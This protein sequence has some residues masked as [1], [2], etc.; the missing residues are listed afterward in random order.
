MR[1]TIS[2]VLE[3]TLHLVL[4]WSEYA[5]CIL[6]K[7][8][9]GL[10]ELELFI[11]RMSNVAAI[12]VQLIYFNPND[13]WFYTKVHDYLTWTFNQ[14]HWRLVNSFLTWSSLTLLTIYP[15]E[16]L[17][18]QT[19]LQHVQQLKL[20]F[21]SQ[22]MIFLNFKKVAY[23]CYNKCFLWQNLCWVWKK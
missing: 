6:H 21:R 5:Q 20:P 10:S 23:I 2:S 22:L 17:L 12:S 14:C 13:E 7:A 8:I 18:R 3:V 1:Y 19:Q 15:I 11:F 4:L 9:A 16:E